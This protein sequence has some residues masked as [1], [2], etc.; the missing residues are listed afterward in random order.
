MGKKIYNFVLKKDWDEVARKLRGPLPNLDN[1]NIKEPQCDPDDVICEPDADELLAPIM[2]NATWNETAEFS[3]RMQ[4]N[5]IRRTNP[6]KST[7]FQVKY[8]AV[9]NYSG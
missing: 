3:V 9:F 8:S 7:N 5:L 2:K 1:P 4:C 6:S